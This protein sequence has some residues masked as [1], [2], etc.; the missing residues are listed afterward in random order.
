MPA[1]LEAVG[2]GRILYIGMWVQDYFG[3]VIASGLGLSRRINIS[4][5]RSVWGII[6]DWDVTSRE[7]RLIGIIRKHKKEK[8]LLESYIWRR[9]LTEPLSY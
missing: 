6:G 1:E 2:T 7:T 5:I 9:E 3:E 8:F 4:S